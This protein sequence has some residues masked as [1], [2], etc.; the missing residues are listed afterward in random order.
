M[1][2]TDTE[3]GAGSAET[4]T[5]APPS[6]DAWHI[7]FVSGS[8]TTRAPRTSSTVTGSGLRRAAS[9]L[10]RAWLYDLAATAAMTSGPHWV[11]YS[12]CAASMA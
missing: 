6:T 4:T 9:G 8:A 12:Q 7:I 1:D 11:S 3:R 10:S 2:S 5:A